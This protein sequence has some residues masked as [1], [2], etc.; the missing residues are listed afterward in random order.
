[1]VITFLHVSIK[2]LQNQNQP[3]HRD[4]MEFSLRMMVFVNFL[5]FKIQ[6][7]MSHKMEQS[8]KLTE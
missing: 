4:H 6:P 7:E 2:V 5:N 8:K 3:N 1:M